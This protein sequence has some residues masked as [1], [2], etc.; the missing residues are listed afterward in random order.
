MRDAEQT[1]GLFLRKLRKLPQSGVL[2]ALCRDLEPRAEGDRL[3]LV[4]DIKT[5][6]DTLRGEKHHAAMAEVLG[7]LGVADFEV[8][9]ALA[10]KAEEKDGLEQLKRDFEGYPVEVK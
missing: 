6:A 5:V 1:F 10:A 2:Y 7:G 4:T 9:Y 8:R 3:V